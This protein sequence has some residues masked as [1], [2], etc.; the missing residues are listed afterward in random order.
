[1]YQVLVTGASGFIGRALCNRILAEGWFFRGTTRSLSNLE[2]LPKNYEIVETGPIGPKT[3]WEIALEDI[4]T[5]VHLAAHVHVMNASDSNQNSIYRRVNTEGSQ[6]L[7][8][9]AVK[10]KV[11]KFIY[12]SSIKVNGEGKKSA[13]S[14]S[15]EPKPSDPY[16]LSKWEAE[17]VLQQI[18]S[19][20]NME[21]VILRPPLVYGPGVKANFLQL[22]KIIEKGLPLPLANVKNR[23]SFIFMGNLIDII[24]ACIQNPKAAG[25]T[26][27]VSDGKDISTPDLIRQLA[28]ALGKSPLLF[29]APTPLLKQL[30]RLVGMPELTNR[31][32]DSLWIDIS[33]IQKR[34]NWMP[35]YDLEEGLRITADWYLQYCCKRLPS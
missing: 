5:V 8:K 31:L 17:K 14:E 9:I 19:D 21:L 11:R 32:L 25:E 22:I 4:D 2:N 12:L 33:K 16:G 27:L 20:S 23:R 18:V 13:Y 1:L 30:S 3:N 15:D 35:P 24:I 6:E 7:A 34:L 28:L 29:S 10:K 26:F